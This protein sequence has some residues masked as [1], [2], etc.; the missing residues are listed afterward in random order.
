MVGSRVRENALSMFIGIMIGMAITATVYGF[1]VS[2]LE[3]RLLEK[4][5][6]LAKVVQLDPAEDLMA[7]KFLMDI[8]DVYKAEVQRYYKKIR[9]ANLGKE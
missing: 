2:D 9:E 3:K 7:K 8:G 4:T 5:H 6:D 1:K